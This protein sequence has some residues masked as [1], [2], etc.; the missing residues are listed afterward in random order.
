MISEYFLYLLSF[1]ILFCARN[2]VL[3]VKSYCI[4]WVYIFTTRT[5]ILE[6]VNLREVKRMDN[7]D[8]IDRMDGMGFKNFMDGVSE[9]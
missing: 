4:K 2:L 1:P 9:G 6:Q 3:F 8:I 7:M 5:M